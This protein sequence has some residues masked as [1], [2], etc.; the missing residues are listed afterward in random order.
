VTPDGAVQVTK[1]CELPKFAITEVGAL[2][3]KLNNEDEL[4][5]PSMFVTTTVV[6]PAIP[7]GAVTTS[8]VVLVREVTVALIPPM[9]TW[10]CTPVIEKPVPVM[11]T[12]A[13]EISPIDVGEI[14]VITGG[15]TM[16]VGVVNVPVAPKVTPESLCALTLK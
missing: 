7:E 1:D 5:C 10:A 12:D 3:V 16:P 8:P 15:G 13:P 6:D 14:C 4:L 9:V 2:E 11:V